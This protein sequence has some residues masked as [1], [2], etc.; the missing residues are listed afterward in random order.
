MKPLIK[1]TGVLFVLVVLLAAGAIRHGGFPA[2]AADEDD[3]NTVDKSAVSGRTVY[4]GRI[5]VMIKPDMQEKSA[6]KVARLKRDTVSYE[7]LAIGHIVDITP[8][9]ELR[10][11]YVKIQADRKMTAASLDYST[12]NVK[13][14][15]TLHSMDSNISNREL[16]EARLENTRESI[17][18]EALDGE[19]EAIRGQVMQDWG[20]VLTNWALGGKAGPLDAL[21]QRNE[22]LVMVQ[23]EREAVPAASGTVYM[24]AEDDRG[25]ARKAEFISA[26]TRAAENGRG[27]TYYYRIDAA[28]LRS[29][30]NLYV[31]VPDPAR[32]VS[33][34][35][36]P[37]RAIVWDNGKP[38]YYIKKTADLFVKQ[39]AA[40][41]VEAASG[42]LLIGIDL[43]KAEVVVQGSQLLLSEENRR[44]IP[45]ED[46]DT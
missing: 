18:L 41:H 40:D 5:A 25:G 19:L 22:V 42:W 23:P 6:I 39:S 7:S 38:W 13:R 1:R 31:W 45:E 10:S 32:Q 16:Q 2:A 44:Q 15:E 35:I 9:L 36:L 4:E 43:S 27:D 12:R 21:L 8:L 20:R 26:A 24:N 33:G 46:N 3:S 28:G 37:R 34:Y 11:R 14:L 17:R 29:G 30:M